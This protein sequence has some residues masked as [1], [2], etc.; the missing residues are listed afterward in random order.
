MNAK[1]LKTENSPRNPKSDQSAYNS[2]IRRCSS[3]ARKLI[4]K[5]PEQAVRVLFHICQQFSKCPCKAYYL[6]KIFSPELQNWQNFQDIGHYIFQM[7]KHKGRKD[8]TKLQN[9]VQ[10]MK[11]KFSS[12]RKAC[13]SIN[14]LWTKFYRFTRIAKAKPRKCEFTRKLSENQ[15]DCI[16]N[17]MASDDITFSLPEAKYSGKRFFSSSVICAQK[18]YNMLPSCTSKVSLSTY[19]KYRPKKFRLQGRIPFQQSCCE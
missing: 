18:M 17:H 5:D 2:F 6:H 8:A 11:S 10:Q 12:L 1:E 13:S 9:T 7:G 3:E 15:I 16:Q 19:Y 4:P 14:C